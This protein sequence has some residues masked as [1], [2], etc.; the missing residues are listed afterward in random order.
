MIPLKYFSMTPNRAFPPSPHIGGG[1]TGWV[2]LRKRGI[3]S[4]G[5]WLSTPLEAKVLK[6][7][8]LRR[9]HLLKLALLFIN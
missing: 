5:G 1:E 4:G 9:S 8:I 7:Q 3:F 2:A 6:V